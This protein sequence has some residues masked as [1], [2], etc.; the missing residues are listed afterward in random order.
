MRISDIIIHSAKAGLVM[1]DTQNGTMPAGEMGRIGDQET[2]VRNTGHWAIQ[3][4]KAFHITE[5][6]RF[7]DAGLAAANWLLTR[8]ARP[9]NA[10]FWH[11]MNPNKDACNGVI[12]T[13]FSIGALMAAYSSTG[14]KQ[15]Q[16]VAREVFLL[17]PF[18][19]KRKIWK[20]VNVDGSIPRG[21]FYDFDLTF[22]HQV[23]L[24]MA[25]SLIDPG[26]QTEIGARVTSFLDGLAET[27]NLSVSRDGRIYDEIFPTV[28]A[29]DKFLS[30]MRWTHRTL[31]L[32]R[33]RFM[34]L[35][36]LN[37]QGYSLFNLARIAEHYPTHPL[38]KTSKL[39]R[40]ICMSG[41]LRYLQRI[42]GNRDSC[43]NRA[44]GLE[45]A[46]ALQVFGSMNICRPQVTPEQWA[47]FELE[48]H[49]DYSRN[50]LTRNA[51]NKANQAANL[52]VATYLNDFEIP[53]QSCPSKSQLNM[54]FN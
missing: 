3:F 7:R 9:M 41:T 2:P 37:Y 18:C 53:D 27:G 15:F 30:T 28:T 22:N 45:I 16:K 1:Q 23:W 17:H 14:N 8:E 33:K 44:T 24:A 12:G 29:V 40:A 5:D 36:E 50:L 46:K 26:K 49:F 21:L 42:S 19:R 51:I 38:W 34:V 6:V 52:Y 13:A 20:R 48:Y 54:N 35:K 10:T 11:R 31:N 39:K 43:W 32:K 25:G 47:A 4:F